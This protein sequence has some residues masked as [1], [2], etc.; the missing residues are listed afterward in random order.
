MSFLFVR[1]FCFFFFFTTTTTSPDAVGDRS[2]IGAHYRGTC[3]PLAEFLSS[4]IRLNQSQLRGPTKMQ[5]HPSFFS[6]AARA[7]FTFFLSEPRALV[8]PSHGG[9][10]ARRSLRTSFHS[11]R[12]CHSA[13]KSFFVFEAFEKNDDQVGLSSWIFASIMPPFVPSSTLSKQCICAL[14]RTEA[15]TGREELSPPSLSCIAA[16]F[17]SIWSRVRSGGR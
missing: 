15:T 7:F 2:A 12:I 11:S 6:H 14:D 4:A 16:A 10:S 5:C 3:L 8:T 13:R 9:N 1:S 17:R